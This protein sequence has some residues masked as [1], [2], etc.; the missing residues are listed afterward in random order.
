MSLIAIIV[1]IV[2][3]VVILAVLCQVC[4]LE[5]KIAGYSGKYKRKRRGSYSIDGGED[6]WA[7]DLGNGGK[8]STSIWLLG[9]KAYG[10]NGGVVE[11]VVQSKRDFF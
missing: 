3:V 5:D 6:C 7:G 11:E 10:E 1:V 9:T 4:C 8:D 2:V